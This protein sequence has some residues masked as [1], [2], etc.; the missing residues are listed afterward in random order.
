M[1]HGCMETQPT[2]LALVR[3][4]APSRPHSSESHVSPLSNAAYRRLTATILSL[5][6]ATLAADLK[7]A[8]LQR[9]E[10]AGRAA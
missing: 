8:R 5:D 1:H 6:V 2:H 10:A 4:S 7:S 9:A 3:R